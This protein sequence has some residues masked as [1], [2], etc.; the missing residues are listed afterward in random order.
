MEQLS[1]ASNDH[2]SHS[3]PHSYHNEIL[4]QF[5]ADPTQ[6]EY[7]FSH[8][9]SKKDRSELHQL[10]E[11]KGLY[12]DSI[13]PGSKRQLIVRKEKVETQLEITD[14]DRKQFIKDFSLPFPVYREPYFSYYIELYK[15]F[16]GTKEKYNIFIDALKKLKEQ[17]RQLK[18]VSYEI[19]ERIIAT[20][21]AVP[22]YKECTSSDKYAFK[23][24]PNDTS[25]YV[26]N[27]KE[28][29]QYYISLDIIKANFSSCKFFDPKIV[30]GCETWEE[31]MAKFTDIEYFVQAKHFRQV[32]FGNLKIKRIASIQRYLLAELY[33]KIKNIV[34]VQGKVSTDEIIIKTTKDTIASDCQKI[35]EVIN[36]LPDNMKGIWKIVPLYIQPIGNSKCFI[37]RTIIDVNK[38]FDN[39]TNVKEEIKNIEKDFY[40]QAFKFYTGQTLNSNDMKA[41]KDDC[42][43]TYD[44]KY[45]F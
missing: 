30:L 10:C 31:L 22:E 21:K 26:N 12:S 28:W 38:S 4:D 24:L 35:A 25:I 29:P 42:L 16:L 9:L 32:V 45:E 19:L 40:A 11:Q 44:D 36:S 15:D 37:K 41:L 39:K 1:Q 8:L 3:A 18:S 6:K 43:I 20:I 33:H 34:H 17:K 7:L 13:G 23:D 14:E 27:S 2:F 5:K